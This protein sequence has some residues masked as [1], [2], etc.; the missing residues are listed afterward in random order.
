IVDCP[1]STPKWSSEG[2]YCVRT[3]AFSPFY[4]DLSYQG[5]VDEE[6]YQIEYKGSNLNLMIF[7]T[8]VKVL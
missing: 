5:Y 4:L 7:Y 3:T 1:H 8:V 2:K 6:T